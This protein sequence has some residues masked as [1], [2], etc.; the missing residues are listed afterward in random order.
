M[1]GVPFVCVDEKDTESPVIRKERNVYKGNLSRVNTVAAL[2]FVAFKSPQTAPLLLTV[3]SADYCVLRTQQ[4][5]ACLET[6]SLLP[7]LAAHRLFPLAFQ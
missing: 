6:G 5:G 7:P 3:G 1:G 2:L 4:S